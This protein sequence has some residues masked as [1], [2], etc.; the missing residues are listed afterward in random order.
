MWLLPLLWRNQ[1]STIIGLTITNSW[2]NRLEDNEDIQQDASIIN[3]GSSQQSASNKMVDIILK[4]DTT[5]QSQTRTYQDSGTTMTT[6]NHNSSASA[7]YTTSIQ[8]VCSGHSLDSIAME[9]IHYSSQAIN[10]TKYVLSRSKYFHIDL[11]GRIF[12]SV[13]SNL[14]SM[15]E[16]YGLHHSL[17]SKDDAVMVESSFQGRKDHN[18]TKPRIV[19]QTEQLL[20]QR[21]LF[22]TYLRNCFASSLCVVWDFSDSNYNI[23]QG[24]GHPD[25]K[26][27]MLLLP[28]MIQNRLDHRGPLAPTGQERNGSSSVTATATA[29]ELLRQVMPPPPPPPQQ[30][31]ELKSLRERQYD[32]VFFG[33]MTPR[34]MALKDALQKLP[35]NTQF[36]NINYKHRIS[37]MYGEAKICLT[38]HADTSISGG[39]LHRLTDFA[40]KGCIPLMEKWNDTIGMDVYTA[41]GKCGGGV[42][43]ASHDD[44]VAAATRLLE[45]INNSTEMEESM[46]V[47]RVKW[48]RKDIEWPTLLT[49]AFAA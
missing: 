23:A 48:W 25:F 3:S 14:I 17:L 13:E 49:R 18:F 31:I 40:R 22:V 36:E 46:M 2:T 6:N 20:M 44:L 38:I 47:D 42:V 8:D 10:K 16:G 15:L 12:Q 9:M 1:D 7:T 30:M 32:V 29:K 5:E 45:R 19:I 35:W 41:T 43:F 34:R 28:T 11:S 39:E 21:P 4:I 26:T 24:W 33:R 27:S 37:Q